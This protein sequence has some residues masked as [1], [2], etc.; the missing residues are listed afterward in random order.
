MSPGMRSSIGSPVFPYRY[1]VRIDFPSPSE[2]L[3]LDHPS[4][5]AHLWALTLASASNI[6]GVRSK[7]AI[8][9]APSTAA[10][11]AAAVEDARSGLKP[12]PLKCPATTSVESTNPRA[13]RLVSSASSA[14]G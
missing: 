2:T 14:G 5:A 8:V 3:D 4:E 9:R 7:R 6:A 1:S 11:S 10:T 12:H 13:T